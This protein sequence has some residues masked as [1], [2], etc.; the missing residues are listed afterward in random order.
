L[1][2]QWAF[3]A[4]AGALGALVLAVIWRG[5]KRG[6]ATQPGAGATLATAPW[7]AAAVGLALLVL[8]FG[9]YG[10]RGNPGALGG[11]RAAL[12][13]QLLEQG[14]PPSGEAAEALYQ[15][16]QGHLKK[17]PG[18]PRAL[19]LKARLDMQ[20]ERFAPAVVAFQGAL[21]G[22]SKVV[23]DAGVWVEY[24]EAVGMAQGRTLVGE[25]QRLVLKALE[26]DA[27]HPQ[28]LDLAGSAAWE[29]GDYAGAVAYWKRLLVLLSPGSPRHAPLQTAIER[30]EQRARF[31]L[32]ARP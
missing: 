30:A 16:L 2:P 3:Y 5:F 12:S 17:Q 24:A 26:L 27:R 11:E 28:A 25:P 19:V 8:A 18:D 21:A 32:P 20:A 13:E 9:L 14:L 31:A 4:L 23:N 6:A 15:T 7:K 22:R 10:L 29:A 1:N